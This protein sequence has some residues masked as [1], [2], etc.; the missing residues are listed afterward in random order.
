LNSF[1]TTIAH[2]SYLGE[3][4]QYG[5]EIARGSIIKAVEHNPLE[6]RRPG[7][8]LWVHIRPLDF[9]VLSDKTR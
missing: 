1:K 7:S 2:T 4:E 9:L 8:A 6:I 3:I 5:L